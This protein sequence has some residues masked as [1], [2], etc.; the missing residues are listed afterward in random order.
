MYSAIRKDGVRLYELARQGIEV[1][2]T[3]RE[4]EIYELDVMKL[5]NGEYSLYCECSA[6]TYIRT[7]ISDIGEKL[8]CGATMTSLSRTF[9]CGVELS[10]CFNLEEL[11]ELSEKGEI[12]KAVIPL[13]RLLVDYPAL[14]VTPNQ[15]KRFS[16]G[17]G[18]LRERLKGFGENGLYRVYGN[19]EFLGL[20]D[21]DNTE[22]KV[23]RVYNNV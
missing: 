16:N 9:A 14:N 3:P 13:D 12:Q 18:L 7:L 6:G 4:C 21:L 17:G 23:K 5:Q 1:E 2:R 15:A 11:R 20:G 22:L 19:G 10:Q 8:G